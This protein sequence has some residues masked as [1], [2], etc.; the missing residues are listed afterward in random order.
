MVEGAQV[1]VTTVDENDLD[2][3]RTFLSR[4]PTSWRFGSVE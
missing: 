4:R 1:T 2:P 3:R